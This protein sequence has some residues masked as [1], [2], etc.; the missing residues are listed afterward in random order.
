VCV[1]VCGSSFWQGGLPE[2]RLGGAPPRPRGPGSVGRARRGRARE[3]A[4]SSEAVGNGGVIGRGRVGSFAALRCRTGRPRRQRPTARAENKLLQT[5]WAARVCGGPWSRSRA[6]GAL[7]GGKPSVCQP[8]GAVGLRPSRMVVAWAAVRVC[9]P[10]G[11]EPS[12]C[13]CRRP[14]GVGG[15][16]AVAGWLAAARAF[17]ATHGALKRFPRY[18]NRTHR[19]GVF[20]SPK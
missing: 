13:A 17:S 9:Q 7:K 8:A 1:R 6:H 5:G 12:R 11:P 20:K 2:G 10:A 3:A 19:I 18:T 16:G 4:K 15:S 14:G